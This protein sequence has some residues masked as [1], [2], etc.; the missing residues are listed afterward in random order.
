MKEIPIKNTTLIAL[1][2]D[3]DYLRLID[4]G[5][6]YL[7]HGHAVIH[8]YKGGSCMQHYILNP[9]ENELD[10]VNHNTLDNQKSNLRIATRSQNCANRRKFKNNKSGFIGV[11]WHKHIQKYQAYI[12][13]D[14]K[15]THLGSFTDPVEAAKAR[16]AKAKEFFGEFAKLNFP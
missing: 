5:P 9:G 6:W 3:E 13:K 11:I 12:S 10:H 4:L 1:V 14:K 2:D 7:H 8:G 16:D 15:I